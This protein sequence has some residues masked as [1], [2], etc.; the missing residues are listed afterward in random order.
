MCCEIAVLIFVALTLCYIL[1]YNWFKAY[2]L[3]KTKRNLPEWTYVFVIFSFPLWI[4]T[5]AMII[6]Y[7]LFN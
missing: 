2:F 6:V 3:N 4:F 7:A 1:H 5:F